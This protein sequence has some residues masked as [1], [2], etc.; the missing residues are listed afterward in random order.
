MEDRQERGQEGGMGCNNCENPTEQEYKKEHKKRGRENEN[1]KKRGRDREEPTI[2]WRDLGGAR[3]F[4]SRGACASVANA[5]A[6]AVLC[7]AEN[8]F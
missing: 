4:T 8:S 3:P 1:K 2:Q 5:N 6:D 7:N